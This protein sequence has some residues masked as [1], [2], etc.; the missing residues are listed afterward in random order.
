MD[1][2]TADFRRLLHRFRFSP[3]TLTVGLLT[4]AAVVGVV[5]WITDLPAYLA[6]PGAVE[7]WWVGLAALVGS[8]Q[9]TGFAIQLI[10]AADRRIPVVATTELEWAEAFT[11]VVTPESSG[12]FALSIRF[13]TK[14][15]FSSADATAAS[16]F[17][18]FLTTMVAAVVLAVSAGVAAA[19]LD[20]GALK[21]D[22]PSSLWEFI[23]VVIAAAVIV[24]LAIKL[25]RFRKWAKNWSAQAGR[26]VRTIIEHPSRGAITAG[27]ELFSLASQA[28][29][30]CLLMHATH[31]PVN[32]A[33]AVVITQIA[34]TASSVV[35]IPGGLGAPEAILV[36]GLVGIGG[37]HHAAVIASLTYR[38]ITYWLPP[39]PGL[40]ALYDLHRRKQV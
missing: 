22:V 40:V 23:V 14:R 18:S 3:V 31:I 4:F 19:T 16:G 29:C 38:M 36:A 9:Y 20:V 10:G 12:S 37:D 33:A 8:F 7:W 26:Y 27:G 24:T 11:F 5:L 30:L 28:G 6:Q 1:R 2:S 34:G 35:P 39:L 25:P 13:L 32:V 21:Q 17:S 15:G